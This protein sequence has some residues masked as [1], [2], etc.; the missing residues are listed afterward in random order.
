MSNRIEKKSSES[1]DEDFLFLT[2]VR[3]HNRVEIVLPA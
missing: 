3:R 1:V 2:F